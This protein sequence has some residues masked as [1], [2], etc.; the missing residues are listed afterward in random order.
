M[1]DELKDNLGTDATNN[2][3]NAIDAAMGME[4]RMKQFR[5]P[6]EGEPLAPATRDQIIAAVREHLRKFDLSQ[7]EL[8][9]AIGYMNVTV[10]QVLSGKYKGEPDGVLRAMAGFIEDDLRRRDQSRPIGF[11]DTNIF[12]AIRTLAGYAKTNALSTSELDSGAAAE[13]PRIV[14]GFGPAGLGKTLG[15]RAYAREDPNAIYVRI[16]KGQ[17]RA[18]HFARD[19]CEAMSTRNARQP[20]GAV[21]HCYRALRGSQRLLICDEFHRANFEQ[22]EFIRDLSDVCGIPVLLLATQEFYQ[23]ISGVRRREGRYQYDQF[24]SRVGYVVDLIKGT[25][26]LGGDKRPIFS[27]EEV[28]AIFK[29]GQLRLAPDAGQFLQALACTIGGGMLR[30]CMAVFD[31][32]ARTAARKTGL[33]TLNLLVDSLDRSLVPTGWREDEFIGK[34]REQLAV[35]RDYESRRAVAG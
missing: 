33:I 22:C 4:S 14:I 8:G 16:R 19:I 15:A 3:G 35:N 11:Y 10:S 17:G 32:A 26:G 1:S 34:V 20:K 31:K 25:D 21:D 6:D 27:L 28:L 13:K 30:T 24:A 5:L 18:S 23:R 2:S 7:K 12:L 29:R 9:A